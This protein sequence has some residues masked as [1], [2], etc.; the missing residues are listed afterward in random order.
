MLSKIRRLS[1]PALLDYLRRL[2]GDPHLLTKFRVDP[3]DRFQIIANL[4]FRLFGWK[5]LIRAPKCFRD[6]TPKCET[7]VSTRSVGNFALND[8]QF[9]KN[10]IQVQ[11]H[12]FCKLK[13]KMAAV[14]PCSII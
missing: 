10:L 7:A 2:F 14:P 13:C 5:M 6:L 3:I 8:L 12:G 1:N 9:T 4:I 11:V